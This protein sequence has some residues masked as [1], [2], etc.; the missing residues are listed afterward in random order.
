[1]NNQTEFS[2]TYPVFIHEEGGM[3]WAN[4][5]DVPSAFTSGNTV[6]EIIVKIKEAIELA[7][8]TTLTVPAATQ[9]SEVDA[10]EGLVWMVGCH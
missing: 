5:P 1:M 2:M 3:F 6:E 7:L 10:K 4:V 8:S 9:F